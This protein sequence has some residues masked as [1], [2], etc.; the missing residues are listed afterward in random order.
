MP[1]RP[2]NLNEISA[3]DSLA[4]L[5]DDHASKDDDH[6][7][8]K[9]QQ[10][11]DE[12]TFQDVQQGHDESNT[13]L[14]HLTQREQIPPSDICHI[15][16]TSLARPKD[17]D[18]NTTTPAI[19]LSTTSK[20]PGT[21]R[22]GNATVIYQASMHATTTTYSVSQHESVKMDYSG[23]VDRGANGVTAG[24][25][26]GSFPSDPPECI[27][28]WVGIYEH[29]GHRMTSKI[30][31][32]NNTIIARSSIRAADNAMTI[33]KRAE[34][35]NEDDV[36]PIV[37]SIHDNVKT[38][39]QDTLA[40]SVDPPD[41]E[42]MSTLAMPVFDPNDLVG[43][44]AGSNVRV[45]PKHSRRVNVQGIDNHQVTDIPIG[46]PVIGIGGPVLGILHQAA[47]HG[48]GRTIISCG[49]VQGIDNHQVTDIPIGGPMIG[50]GGPVIGI[51]HQA[52]IHD[53]GRTI[54]SCG[55]L[56]YFGVT[57]DDKS[58]KVGGK[59][60]MRTLEGYVLPLNFFSGLAYLRMVPYSDHEWDSLP[61]VIPT[62]D[63][64]WDPSVLNYVM[65]DNEHWFDALDEPL[66]LPGDRD[67]DEYSQY[68]H[69]HIAATT[70][71]THVQEYRVQMVTDDDMSDAASD[72]FDH[73]DM[74]FLDFD[75]L[76]Q[77]YASSTLASSYG[78]EKCHDTFSVSP[79]LYARYLLIVRGGKMSRYLL[80]IP[81]LSSRHS[82]S[83]RPHL[84]NLAQFSPG[85][86]RRLCAPTV[87][88]V[89]YGCY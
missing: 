69:R 21:T 2:V 39:S 66:T 88:L 57:I 37:K 33:N 19:Q 35:L 49:Q 56:E 7:D 75:R 67:L 87:C 20:K 73:H 8:A 15:L 25:S 3:H 81:H 78:E 4:M 26:G 16:S 89:A 54:I 74:A 28:R 10:G 62:G 31:T 51:F 63:Q 9:D 71:M 70:D 23:L 14:A 50:I 5:H 45:I 42:I 22:K 84:L 58:K 79:Q 30:L 72:D 1:T 36:S 77:L 80:S 47:I 29:V 53:H 48:H 34:P 38:N 82:L 43:V 46:G 6:T 68:R 85:L 18:T 12:L 32:E 64:D 76:N 65:D 52:A 86:L 55:Q 11:N 59:Q 13:I 41:P 83:R 17:N 27:G 40:S 60:C 61:H 44:I 24:S